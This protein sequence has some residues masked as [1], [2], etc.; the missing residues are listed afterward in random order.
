[1]ASERVSRACP[2]V[3]VWAISCVSIFGRGGGRGRGRGRGRRGG[4]WE[5]G[6]VGEWESGRVGENKRDKRKQETLIPSPSHPIPP[7]S[8]S[9]TPTPYSP[10]PLFTQ[11]DAS[12]HLK[13]SGLSRR[14]GSSRSILPSLGCGNF[15]EFFSLLSVENVGKTAIDLSLLALH[16]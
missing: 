11:G 10:L 3:L 6:R 13:Q 1:M 2:A 15:V 9:P 4:E 12:R 8:P 7:L 5:R 16:D 14:S